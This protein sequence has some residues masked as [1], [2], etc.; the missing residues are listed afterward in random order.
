M[1][2][3]GL[4]DVFIRIMPIW[5]IGPIMK[6]F[7]LTYNTEIDYCV[8]LKQ[9]VSEWVLDLSQYKF[10]LVCF[11]SLFVRTWFLC[12][13][14]WTETRHKYYEGPVHGYIEL[15]HDFT[16]LAKFLKFFQS[17]HIFGECSGLYL[18]LPLLNIGNLHTKHEFWGYSTQ[19]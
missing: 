12:S 8:P 2:R 14:E 17:K 6:V 11:W 5:Q 7:W 4:N 3:L 16:I 19:K 9:W 10:M 15:I 18:F 13:S 1:I